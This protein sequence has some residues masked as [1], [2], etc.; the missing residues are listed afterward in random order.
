MLGVLGGNTMFA[1]DAIGHASALDM[2]GLTFVLGAMFGFVQGYIVCEQEGFPPAVFMDSINSLLP[3]TKDILTAIS[4]RI[5]AKD[6]ASNEATI[7][8]WSVAPRELLAW[9][10]DRGMDNAIAQVQ[11]SLFDKAIGG[12]HG[13][14][15]FAYFYEIM[16]KASAASSAR[17][18]GS[19]PA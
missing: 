9:C 2:A 18:V 12:G 11:Q 10:Q 13:Q 8:A 7:D 1:G 5:P 3:A 17:T 4:A 16:R 15:D 14:A 19:V 6:Y